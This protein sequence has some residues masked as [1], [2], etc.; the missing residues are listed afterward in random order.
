MEF[1]L[2][3]AFLLLFL[4]KL[5]LL[6][7]DILPQIILILSCTV[8]AKIFKLPFFH[9]PIRFLES[10]CKNEGLSSRSQMYRDYLFDLYSENKNVE[11]YICCIRLVIYLNC[12]MMHGLTNFK[13][14][15]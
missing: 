2:I 15:I 6:F 11:M 13:F 7:F 14:Y 10:G 12:T 4:T 5:F 1:T 3:Q 8:T 9:T